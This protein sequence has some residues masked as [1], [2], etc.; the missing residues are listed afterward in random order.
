M[1][2]MDDRCDLLCLDLPRAEEIR[3]EV[4]SPAA[5]E[6]ASVRARALADA[7]RL[8]VAAVL[9]EGGELCVC[10][11]AWIVGR[12]QGLVSHHLRA[13]R[14]AGLARSRRDGKMVIYSLTEGGAALV[15]AVVAATEVHA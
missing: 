5:A 15:A 7:T 14:D 11:V 1:S 6:T 8:A 13:L 3:R 9:R 10:D 2:P 12:S 4:L